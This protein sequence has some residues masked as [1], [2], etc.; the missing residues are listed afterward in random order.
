MEVAD[1]V[2]RIISGDSDAEDEMVRRYK[3]GV[4]VII[5]RIVQIHSVRED[6]FQDTF[7]KAIEKIRRGEVRE[8]ERVS[9]FICKLAKNL[10]IDYIRKS[11]QAV[12][13]T[14]GVSLDQIPDPAPDQFE[15]LWRKER[16]EVIRR[17]IA[18]LKIKRDREIV[19]RYFIAEEEKDEICA[20]IGLNRK[21]FNNVIFRAVKRYAK[22]YIKMI[23][24]P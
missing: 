23:G 20:E 18:E 10:A 3:D 11:R 9:G 15:Q 8:P 19:F 17:V 1:L 13:E 7:K 2:R 22:L 5:A 12:K 24:K 21:Q 6:L 14:E 16:R 4:S